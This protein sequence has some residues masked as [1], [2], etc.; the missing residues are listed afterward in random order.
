MCN[1]HMI[2]LHLSVLLL[3]VLTILNCILSTGLQLPDW[4]AEERGAAGTTEKTELLR[5]TTTATAACRHA[6]K[7]FGVSMSVGCM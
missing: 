5:A 2:V 4:S 6:N 3:I 7:S 1:K